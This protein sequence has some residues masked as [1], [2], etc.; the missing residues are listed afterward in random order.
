MLIKDFFR[1][2]IRIIKEN[3]LLF[4][5]WMILQMISFYL[6]MWTLYNYQEANQSI[7]QYQNALHW[8]L[9][10]TIHVE[11]RIPGIMPEDSYMENTQQFAESCQNSP[12]INK[13]GIFAYSND[14][15]NDFSYKQNTTDISEEGIV[16]FLYIDI[17]SRDL[18]CLEVDQYD[19]EMEVQNRDKIPVLA[20]A[21]Y[22][23]ASIGDVFHGV[24]NEYI[25]V[26][27]LKEN[28]IW[29][30]NQPMQSENGNICLDSMFV[31]YLP[32]QMPLSYLA[33]GF[34]N[35]YICC[36]K[37][38]IQDAKKTIMQL[39]SDNGLIGIVKTSNEII[40]DYIA[41]SKEDFSF[42]RDIAIMCLLISILSGISIQ[43]LIVHK[44]KYSLAVYVTNGLKQKYIVSI[45]GTII[46]VIT[47]FIYLLTS[48]LCK[49][50]IHITQ[51]LNLKI[52]HYQTIPLGSAICIME[53]MIF[54]M[55]V[56]FVIS[57][58]RYRDLVR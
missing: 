14:Y 9:E 5:L 13:I 33:N 41:E 56:Y 35:I 24:E 42:V 51:E 10:E 26:G 27:T 12:I 49:I 37:N 8:N 23:D 48:F 50:G 46:V 36:D 28:A 22:T 45:Y 31:A 38:K 7:W 21:N 52:Y 30:S 15:C 44:Q 32:T 57:R 55:I 53:I 25:V 39:L 16:D 34:N 54:I 18:C 47:V 6:I 11:I 1:I 17:G 43:F 29:Y 3:K 2:V 4:V 19:A 58:L 40:D 20:G